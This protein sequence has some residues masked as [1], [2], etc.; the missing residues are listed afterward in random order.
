MAIPPELTAFQDEAAFRDRFIIPLLYRLGFSVVVEYHGQR[1]FGRDIIFGEIDRLGH[2][3]YYAL[4]VKY[5]PVINQSESH[6]LVDDARESFAHDFHHPQTQTEER[7][8]RFYVANAGTIATN[9]RDNF[10]AILERPIASNAVL[11]DGPAL[12]S[13]D[14]FAV[15][16]RGTTTRELLSGLL[17]EI[18]WNRSI[19]LDQ[20]LGEFISTTRLPTARLRLA[21]IIAMLERPVILEDRFLHDLQEYWDLARIA[22]HVVDSIDAPFRTADS[23]HQLAH[24]AIERLAELGHRGEF[25]EEA[26]MARLSE[27]GR[28]LV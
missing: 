7:V 15:V 28:T 17:L 9:A 6:G 5:L 18:R 11:L 24:F 3:L 2:V 19:S 27:L 12:L 8:C 4:Q 25:L 10:F 16:N 13:L 21:A 20:R 23:Q 26:L 14:R 1:E 22:N